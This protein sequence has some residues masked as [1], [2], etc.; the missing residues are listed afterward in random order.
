MAKLI[1]T[2]LSSPFESISYCDKSLCLVSWH[3][4]FSHAYRIPLAPPFSRS[5]ASLL[6]THR[7]PFS[8][9]QSFVTDGLIYANT[10][11]SAPS[12]YHLSMS[13]FWNCNGCGLAPAS[14]GRDEYVVEGR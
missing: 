3:L 6:F 1:D 7:L 9:H 11:R 12:I 4:P 5:N 14:P 10:D 2:S 8:I 13:G